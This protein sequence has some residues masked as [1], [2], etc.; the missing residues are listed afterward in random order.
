MKPTKPA[1][2]PKIT[3]EAGW[4]LHSQYGALKDVDGKPLERLEAVH[5][6]LMKRDGL[7][8]MDAAVRVFGPF[9]AD[10]NSEIGMRHGAAKLRPF[11]MLCDKSD[12]AYSL[13]PSS[14]YS[15]RSHLERL[16]ELMPYVPHHHFDRDT[17]EALL[18]AL[19]Q[20]AGEV[21]APY[22]GDFDLNDRP[23]AA[24]AEGY[25]PTV[26]KAREILGPLA[27]RHDLAHKLWGWGVVDAAA[28]DANAASAPPAVTPG[29]STNDETIAP[30]EAQKSAF[31]FTAEFDQLC[32]ARKGRKGDSWTDQEKNILWAEICK[33]PNRTQGLREAM[34]KA[35]GLKDAEAV[36]KLVRGKKRP[37]KLAAVTTVIDG[38]K[39]S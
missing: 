6:L 27:V 14:E 16:A 34:A 9:L 25:F 18:Y 15:D 23:C 31:V 19:A 7:T 10:G 36:S 30:A 11:L 29:S 17:P 8:S 3:P 12:R 37:A 32:E 26:A 1:S 24:F 4:E 39:A 33:F 35:L 28:V 13:F 22:S 38:K 20:M 21:W 2:P 5:A